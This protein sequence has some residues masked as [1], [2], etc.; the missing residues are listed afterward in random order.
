M[1]R[2]TVRELH[3]RTSELVRQAS[4]GVAFVIESRGTPVAELR[5]LTKARPRKLPDLDKLL[6]K[7]PKVP[8]SGKWLEKHRT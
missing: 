4:E 5:P 2:T 1:K 6:S 7:F 3:I 8:D